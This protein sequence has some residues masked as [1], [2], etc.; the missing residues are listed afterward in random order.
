[1][2]D[3]QNKP[4][5]LKAFNTAC[6]VIRT[7]LRCCFVHPKT[8]AKTKTAAPPKKPEVPVAANAPDVPDTRA[9]RIIKE[10]W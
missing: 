8:V 1:M 6:P 3:E 4:T 2:A 5:D 10:Y 7:F 9:Q